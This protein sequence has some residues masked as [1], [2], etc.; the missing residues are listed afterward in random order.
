V[1]PL[2]YNCNLLDMRLIAS[3]QYHG[4]MHMYAFTIH[5]LEIGYGLINPINAD[6][7]CVIW[8]VVVITSIPRVKRKQSLHHLVYCYWLHKSFGSS[9][10][11][12]RTFALF[13]LSSLFCPGVMFPTFLV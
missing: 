5:I 4:H 7:S 9:S 1:F 11:L 10:N 3:N 8:E 6:F 13:S 12:P 2:K